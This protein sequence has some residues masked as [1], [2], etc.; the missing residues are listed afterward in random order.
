MEVEKPLVEQLAY[1]LQSDTWYTKVEGIEETQQLIQSK[2]EEVIKNPEF[3]HSTIEL[4]LQ[5]LE[6]ETF[7]KVLQSTLG[8]IETF[9]TELPQYVS[10]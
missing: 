8:M 7:F 5:V 1:K 3:I 6:K 10:S 2:N 4:A 9:I